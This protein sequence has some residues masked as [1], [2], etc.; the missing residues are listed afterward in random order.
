[1]IPSKSFAVFLLLLSDLNSLCLYLYGNLV[2]DS[3]Y[4]IEGI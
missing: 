1:M 3:V 2:M 4:G